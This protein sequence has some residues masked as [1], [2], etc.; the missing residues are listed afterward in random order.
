MG[1]VA[2]C[3]VRPNKGPV[4]FPWYLRAQDSTFRDGKSSVSHYR[5][6]GLRAYRIAVIVNNRWTVVSLVPPI[7]KQHADLR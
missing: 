2:K 4:T 3:V 7:G 6:S 1:V 5:S